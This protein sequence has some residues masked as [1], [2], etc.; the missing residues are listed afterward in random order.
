[1]RLEEHMD[2]AFVMGVLPGGT[3]ALVL[4]GALTLVALGAGRSFLQ[5]EQLEAIEERAPG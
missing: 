3:T 1:M 5:E 2:L 4:S